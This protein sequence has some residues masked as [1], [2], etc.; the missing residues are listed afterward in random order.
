MEKPF[1][2]QDDAQAADRDASEVGSAGAGIP[3][4]S[5]LIFPLQAPVWELKDFHVTVSWDGD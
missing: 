5:A 3:F 1:A 2:P 4:P